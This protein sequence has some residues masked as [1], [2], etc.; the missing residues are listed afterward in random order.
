LQAKS[1]SSAEYGTDIMLAADIIKHHDQGH[2]LC[3]VECLWGEAIHL[4]YGSL[5]HE[6]I[7]S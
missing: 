7:L 6:V 4:L 3:L 2:F 5:L 1:I